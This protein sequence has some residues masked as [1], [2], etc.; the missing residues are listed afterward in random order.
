[1]IVNVGGA[2][3]PGKCGAVSQMA[4]N[5]RQPA[6]IIFA[7]D[8]SGSMGTEVGFVQENMNEFSRKI[9]E[10]GVDARVI[11]IGRLKDGMSIPLVETEGVCVGAPLGSGMC[12]MDSKPPGYVHIQDNLGD[13]DLFDAFVR[14]Y[15]KYKEYLRPNAPKMLVGVSDDNVGKPVLSP[16]ISTPETLIAAIKGLEPSSPM[17]SKWRY[18]G[19]FCFTKCPFGDGAGTT[20][21][22]LVKQTGGVAGDLC[23]QDFKPVFDELAKSVTQTSAL[24]CDWEIPPPPMGETFSPTK[25][26]VQ[27]TLEGKAEQLLKAPGA[28]EC[29]EREG[30]HYDDPA[31][32]KRV[33]AC[34]TSCRRIQAATEAKVD[35]LFGCET[36]VLF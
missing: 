17:W 11:V 2:N 35:L 8:S 18:S 3:E 16:P 33:V 9:I 28:S 15:P 22:E 23:L 36:V 26:N 25:T 10:S 19:I 14:N 20:H 34:P 30:W 5:T 29:G 7:I 6:D 27:I 21:A 1:M 32:P 4:K 31:S 12:P 24:A 13:W